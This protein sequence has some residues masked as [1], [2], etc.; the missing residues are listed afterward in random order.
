MRKSLRR[1]ITLLMTFMTLILLVVNAV[2]STISSKSS[3]EALSD[4][5]YQTTTNYYAEIIDSWFMTNGA[6]L[7]TTADAAKVV[8]GDITTLR[9][10]LAKI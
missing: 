1:R 7:K 2:I 9:P 10:M 4:N 3:L 5:L 6:I 8:D